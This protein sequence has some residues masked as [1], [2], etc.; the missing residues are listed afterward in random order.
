IVIRY[1]VANGLATAVRFAASAPTG[2]GFVVQA[3][4]G[5][6]PGDYV[7]ASSRT[8]VC[9][10]ATVTSI[11]APAPGYL[12]VAHSAI[13]EAL[14]DTSLLINLGPANRAQ[15]IRYDVTGGVLRTTDLLNKH[16]P[17]PLAPNI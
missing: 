12:D 15:T 16:A 1:G 17:N 11:G 8:G 6:A 5:F 13:A 3:P 4:A 2:D 9:A 14:P 10:A 7:V